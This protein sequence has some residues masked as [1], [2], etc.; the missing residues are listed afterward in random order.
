M[1]FSLLPLD[2][3]DDIIA[4]VLPE[5]FESLA[6]T[7]KKIH[8]RCIPFMERH[9]KLRSQFRKLTYYEKMADPTFSI[10]TAFDLI[11][12]I[13][14][15][16]VVAR[17]IQEAD[18]AVDSRFTHSRPR[19]F[20]ADTHCKGDVAGL[21][22]SSPYLKLAGLDWKEYYDKI[23]EDLEASRYSQ[24]AAAFLMTLLPNAKILKLP[25][26]WK[27]NNTTDKLIDTIVQEARKPHPPCD[28]PSLA[29]ITKFSPSVSIGPG[30][31]FDFDWTKRFLALP[32]VQIFRGPSCVVM[33]EGH[34]GTAPKD[35]YRGFGE[36]LKR[37]SL[38]SCCIDEVGIADFLKH[39]PRLKSLY[40]SHSTKENGGPQ[41]WDICKFVTAI[42][43]EAGSH[44][45]DLSV[46]IRELRGSIPPGKASMRG[47][48]RLQR[49]EFPLEIALCN[50]TAAAG[51]VA[52]PNESEVG[53]S[54][55]H[56]LDSYGSLIDD[57]VPASVFE[58]GLIS[59]GTD[60]HEK[61]L[62]LMFR[63]F[64]AKKDSQLPALKEI[65][66]TCPAGA[67]SVYKNHC[68]RLL[69]ET[70][71]AGVSLDVQLWPSLMATTWNEEW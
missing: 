60:H 34:M 28:R 46:S 8:A 22:S 61:A 1:A 64:A 58:L 57:L 3:L 52:A 33:P 16:P 23:E 20:V 12:R 66:L 71:K 31:R 4:H 44:L 67:D 50:I 53:G 48:Q 38:V 55:D 25:M 68:A 15:E 62:D 6:V 36:N 65:H 13:A 32:N 18:F 5:G 54:T 21:F 70:K 41:D 43:R 7:C 63:D 51:Q 39:T 14:I 47:L 40:Y 2:L 27:P 10:R 69:E 37:V 24:H 29:Q 45:V 35:P 59:P 42:E 30:E 9:N 26:L 49:L 19:E 11:I 56:E 17:Y